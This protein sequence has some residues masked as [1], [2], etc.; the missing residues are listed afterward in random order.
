PTGREPTWPGRAGGSLPPVNGVGLSPCRQRRRG[1]ACDT[2]V[3]A[4][5]QP[6][7]VDTA[8]SGHAQR[9]HPSRTRA[10]IVWP[11]GWLVA[12]T[13]AARSGDIMAGDGYGAAR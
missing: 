11:W 12:G 13:A 2:V 3:T 10:S 5:G 9:R 8:P 7:D 6:R 1:R 4:G